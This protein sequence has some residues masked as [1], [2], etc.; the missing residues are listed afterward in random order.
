MIPNDISKLDIARKLSHPT[1]FFYTSRDILLHNFQT[2][3]RLFHNEEVCYA[4]K[5]NSDPKVLMYLDSIGS[6][7]EAASAYEIDLLLSLGVE[8]YKIVYGTSIKPA[9]QIKQAFDAGVNRFAVDSIEEIDKIAE[10]APG[11]KVFVRTT[12]DDTDSVFTMSERFGAQADSVL[13]MMLHAK[14]RELKPYGI[15][16]YVGSQVRHGELWAKAIAKVRPIIIALQQQGVEIEMLNLGGGFPVHYRNHDDAPT[17]EEIV[18]HINT[19]LHKLPYLPKIMLEPGRG[20]VASSTMLVVEVI[21]RTVRNGKVWLCVDGGIY[22][23]LYEAMIHQGATSYHV[24]PVA[25]PQGEYQTMECVIAGPTGDS[26]DIITKN[27]ILPDYITVGDRLMFDN[28]GAYTI[29]MASPFNGF[30]APE[31]Y[32]G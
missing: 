31:L 6:S 15:S 26:L 13:D 17:L 2:F 14:H 3:S 24:H 11:A 29:S 27:A 28:A 1:P 25:E 18:A 30:P 19:E 4:L 20:I 5:A 21:S 7:F 16:F 9:S 32:I 8:P 12:V 10:Y 23:A 22:N